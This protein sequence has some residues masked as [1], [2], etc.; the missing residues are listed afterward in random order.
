MPFFRMRLILALIAGITLVSVGSTYFDVLAHKHALRLELERRSS[1]LG[2][3][4]QPQ[5][6]QAV[7]GG[8][9]DQIKAALLRMRHPDEAL[10]MAIYSPGGRL[11]AADGP[12]EIFQA[13]GVGPLDKVI[14]RSVEVS[15]FGHRGDWE[16]LEDA[17][18]LQGD[19]QLNGILVI[20]QDARFI[21]S[22]GNAVWQRSFWRIAAFVVLIV[23]VTL[24]MVRWFLMRP[25][26]RVAERMRRLRMG[27][28]DGIADEKI[29]E[30]SL[31]TPLA[32][33]VETMAE[34]LI[35]ARAAA[36]RQ[37]PGCAM[38]A[39]T[40]G[41]QSDWPYTCGSGLVRAASSW[42][43]TASLTCTSGGAE[44]R[45]AWCL[46]AAWSQP[47]S[48][49]CGPATASGWRMAAGAKIR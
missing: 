41:R 23:A 48:R 9:V 29:A 34:S 16:W 36:A 33:E 17:F 19:G 44:R 4:L 37:R 43:R 2:V 8:Q 18:P 49:Y 20:L 27:H 39:N 42:S 12:A 22:E 24:L 30:L 13:L 46:P 3:T 40:A 38:P 31:F 15:V 45:F 25:M 26:M 6:E 32:R 47:L 14:K 11:L 1:W 7:A 28:T 5:M 35:E 10:G 21:R